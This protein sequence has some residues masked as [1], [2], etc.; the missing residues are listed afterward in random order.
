M[1]HIAHLR[2]QFKSMNTYDYMYNITLIKIWKEPLS[3]FWES[4]ASSFE[5]TWIPFHPKML[6]AKLGWVGK[7]VWR[8]R[9][10]KTSSMYFRYFVIISPWK[11][12]GPLFEQICNPIIQGCFVPILVEIGPVVLEKKMKM[13]KVYD[14]DANDDGLRIK[15]DQKSS[16]ELRLRW[17]KKM[18]KV[19]KGLPNVW[20]SWP[21]GWDTSV[22]A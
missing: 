3:T 22:R 6:C 20:I 9:F 13:G 17:A 21:R 1:G 10:F 18:F 7:V 12:T 11:R 19:M 8:W 2:E 4:N 15:F 14:N 16:L 5:Q